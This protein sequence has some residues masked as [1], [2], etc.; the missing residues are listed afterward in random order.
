MKFRPSAEVEEFIESVHIRVG[1]R[2]KAVLGRAGLFLA[3]GEG[4]PANF[5]PSNAQGKDL[6]DETVIGDEL[7]DVVVSALNYRAGKALDENGFR[8]EFRRHFEYGCLRLKDMWRSCDQDQTKFL[9]SLLNLT[10]ADN[11]QDMGEKGIIAP[12]EIVEHKIHLQIF[13]DG[14][15]WFFNEAGAH[16]NGL[17]VISGKPGTGKSQLA[18]DLLAQ[19]AQQGLRFLFFDLKGELEDDPSNERQRENREKFFR[20]TGARNVRLINEPLP[21]NPLISTDSTAGNAQVAYEIASLIRAFAHQ[22]GAKQERAIAEAYQSLDKP[23]FAG[24]AERL[25]QNG[26]IGV[27]YARMKK[28][29]DLNIFANAKSSIDAEEW[30]QSSLVIDFKRFGSDNE[31][32][33]LAVALILN[34][35]MKRLNKNLSVR[36]MIQPMKMVLFIEEAHL[37]LPKEGKAGLVGSL[38][39][40]GRSWGFPVWL[41]SQD[42]EA[43]VT[44]G[45]N[46]T[47]FA[48]LAACGIHFSPESLSPSQQ[49]DILGRTNT[50]PLRPGEAVVRLRDSIKIGNARQ[51]WR[52]GGLNLVNDSESI[53]L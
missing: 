23:D 7:R 53:I 3:I 20:I 50:N 36:D 34:F 25:E 1:A 11:A 51:F 9:S 19:C 29:V 39:R 16:N 28:I 45:T 42:A 44:S 27:E 49:R 14:E 35:L 31:T 47:N 8:Q 38:A 15:Q 21:I 10:T 24:L 17:V 40:Q 2:N 32:K 26:A 12:L 33:G 37:L 22:L 41:A 5:K 52:E 6:D 18:L 43:F 13:K 30:L 46:A 48:D 4:V